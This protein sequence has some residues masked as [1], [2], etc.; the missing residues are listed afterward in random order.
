MEDPFDL[1]KR[2]H[3][4]IEATPENE[5]VHMPLYLMLVDKHQIKPGVVTCMTHLMIYIDHRA[6]IMGRNGVNIPEVGSYEIE[7]ANPFDI[8]AQTPYAVSG[9]AIRLPGEDVYMGRE[10]VLRDFQ[11]NI[12]TESLDALIA[13]FERA[14]PKEHFEEVPVM[15][16]SVYLFR[17][18]RDDLKDL[19]FRK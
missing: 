3:E 18:H 11:E 5:Q 15:Y 2:L 8:H 14:F 12:K 4:I 10:D 16:C 19:K 13:S 1:R 9:K 7:P 17:N 6:R